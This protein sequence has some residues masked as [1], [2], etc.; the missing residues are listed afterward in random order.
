LC[1]VEPEGLLRHRQRLLCNPALRQRNLVAHQRSI[2][3]LDPRDADVAVEFAAR[4]MVDF[5]RGFA[6]VG[7][8]KAT[9]I[10]MP[11]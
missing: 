9:P 3:A 11:A 10:T 7:L 6:R 8:D 4:L 2:N 1:Q 5:Q